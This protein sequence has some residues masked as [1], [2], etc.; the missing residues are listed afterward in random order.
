MF[1]RQIIFFLS[2]G[3]NTHLDT[4]VSKIIC[5]NNYT[6]FRKSYDLA[7]I[8]YFAKDIY[9][10]IKFSPGTPVSSTNKTDYHNITEI[11]LKVALSTINQ[12]NKLCILLVQLIGQ[13]SN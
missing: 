12:T 6:L 3:S 9:S 13:Y 4:T 2:F 5:L 8:V 7:T 1:K 10:V 11:L